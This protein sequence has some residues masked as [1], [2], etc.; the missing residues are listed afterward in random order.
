MIVAEL[1]DGGMPVVR[2]G[3]FRVPCSS[4][5]LSKAD[6]GADTGTICVSR[7]IAASHVIVC[8]WKMQEE[9]V[10]ENLSSKRRFTRRICRSVSDLEHDRHRETAP[11]GT[12]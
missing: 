5:M 12:Y 4:V 1:R 3:K 9:C 11:S 6:R 2:G 7:D 10:T 8:R